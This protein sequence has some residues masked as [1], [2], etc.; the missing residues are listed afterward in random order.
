MPDAPKL[1]LRIAPSN[2]F[3]CKPVDVGCGDVRVA[4]ATEVL[5]VVFGYDEKDVHEFSLGKPYHEKHEKHER[6]CLY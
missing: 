4:V 3:G 5:A 1:R 2:T 6:A